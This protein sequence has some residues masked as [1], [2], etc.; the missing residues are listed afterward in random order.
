M[1]SDQ[2]GKE[3]RNTQV[4]GD[5]KEQKIVQLGYRRDHCRER[6][7]MGWE[8]RDVPGLSEQDC[9]LINTQK[10]AM[11]SESTCPAHITN[12]LICMYT[13]RTEAQKSLWILRCFLDQ[14][15]AKIFLPRVLG[16]CPWAQF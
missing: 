16:L 3:E 5:F 2:L 6:Q 4:H 8:K 10:T 13:L 1:R 7:E 14:K 12:L 9:A 11:F 15:L